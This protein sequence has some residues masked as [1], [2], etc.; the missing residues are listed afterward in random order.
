[1]FRKLQL[2]KHAM[3]G[4]SYML[5]LVVSAGL[6]MAIGNLFGGT[7]ITNVAQIKAGMSIPNAFTT[8][9]VWGFQLLAPVIAAS[10]AYSIADRPGIAPGLLSGFIAYYI[11]AG[12][13][14]GM[15]GGY[16]TGWIVLGLV[17]YIKVPNWAEGL[18]PMLIIPL[19]AG[20]I[21]LFLMF[22]I[23]GQ[24]IVWLTDLLTNFLQGMR[25]SARFI[26]GG[27]LGG[28]AAFDFG[29]PVNK[30]A[31]LFC[32]GLLIQGIK[33]PEA[34]KILASMV[35]PFGITLSYIFSIIFRHPIY[36]QK[37][38]DNIKIAF[39]M[40]ICM[41]TE[42]CIPIA[43]EDLVRVIAS[44]TVGAAIG[45]A[46]NMTFGV[47]SP[48]PSGGMFIVPAM[49]HPLI[50]TVDLLIGS[51]ITAVMLLVWKKAPVEKTEEENED[52]ESEEELDLGS[53]KES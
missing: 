36:T 14:G 9:G 42:G 8:L 4:I 18:R 37:E 12:F 41:I 7:D 27:I 30:V 16:V 48:V 52:N 13:L 49:N 15:I 17:K 51:L 29:G 38:K 32:D 23:L 1:M 25:G 40:G 20:A 35:P 26:F 39:P 50:F 24:P 2:K 19:L 3:T 10:I 45:G 22:Y 5:P 44:C 47:A 34:V 31:S 33:Q 6:L 43:M 11:G 53:I 46:L 28:M 21:D